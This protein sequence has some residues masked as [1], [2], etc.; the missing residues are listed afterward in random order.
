MF[1]ETHEFLI[2]HLDHRGELQVIDMMGRV[3]ISLL[4]EA[5]WDE[6]KLPAFLEEDVDRILN[7]KVCATAK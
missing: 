1:G 4:T 5:E 2:I 6:I 7:I 3:V